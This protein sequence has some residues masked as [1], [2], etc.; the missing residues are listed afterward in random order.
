MHFQNL[1]VLQKAKTYYTTCVEANNNPLLI[2]QNGTALKAIYQD[3]TSNTPLKFAF[4]SANT[5]T[6]HTRL[7]AQEL[8]NISSYLKYEYN[9][10]VL[11]NID[12][13]SNWEN[14]RG[15]FGHKGY[16]IFV[17][18]PTI[19]YTVLQIDEEADIDEDVEEVIE[20]DRK[21]ALSVLNY[22][23]NNKTS[24]FNVFT[25]R[26]ATHKLGLLEFN[27][28]FINLSSNLSSETKEFIQQESFE[29]IVQEPKVLRSLA[30]L[31]K[32]NEISPRTVHNYI[33]YK[34]LDNMA[35]FF[36][37]FENFKTGE[38][39]EL[40]CAKEVSENL[41]DLTSRVYL[42]KVL[43]FSDDRQKMKKH[44][45]KIVERV[46][47]GLQIQIDKLSWMP[48]HTKQLIYK[49]LQYMVRNVMYSNEIIDNQKLTQT[50]S[51]LEINVVNYGNLG[52]LVAE[53][54]LQSVNENGWQW[55]EYAELGYWIDEN[56]KRKFENVKECLRG[57]KVD[58]ELMK[59]LLDDHGAIK[60]AFNAYQLDVD[61][62]GQDNQLPDSI[63]SQLVREQ[64]FFLAYVNGQQEKKTEQINN[65]LMN[66][67]EFKKSFNCRRNDSL[68]PEE[69]CVIW[70]SEIAAVQGIP[71]TPRPSYYV[72]INK[73]PV[74]NTSEYNY[75]SNY[76]MNRINL[77]YQPC[78]NFYEFACS[79]VKKDEILDHKKKVELKMNHKII[80][81]LNT[82]TE[83]E[84][85]YE[86]L[87]KTFYK[88]CI[89]Q[90]YDKTLIYTI[91]N[92]LTT[93]YN[94]TFP[95]LNNGT[96]NKI[97]KLPEIG[98]LA[99][100]LLIN[101]DI[102]PFFKIDVQ[103]NLKKLFNA[104]PYLLTYDTF[105][106]T[107]KPEIY[108]KPEWKAIKQEYIDL[109]AQYLHRISST[110][111]ATMK[112]RTLKAVELEERLAKLLKPLKRYL[113]ADDYNV[114]SFHDFHNILPLYKMSSY[115]RGIYTDNKNY[116]PNFL[117]YILDRHT[118]VA[119]YKKQIQ[120]DIHYGVYTAFVEDTNIF[121]DNILLR[122]ML[123]YMILLPGDAV[124]MSDDLAS[125]FS[126]DYVGNGL[127]SGEK[128]HSTIT[129]PSYDYNTNSFYLPLPYL[130]Y[131]FANSSYP[132]VW[133]FVNIGVDVGRLL[134]RLFEESG[135]ERDSTGRFDQWLSE[136]S[137][138][139]VREMINELEEQYE[140]IS[141]GKEQD[142]NDDLADNVAL[143]IAYQALGSYTL[144]YNDDYSLPSREISLLSSKQLYFL[145]FSQ[146]YCGKETNSLFRV[147]NK[148]KVL[149][150]LSNNIE[151]R[152]VF[153]C[154]K[155]QVYAPEEFVEI[156][157]QKI[158]G[159]VGVPLLE[160]LPP[161]LNI[162]QAKPNLSLK[163]QECA[164][165]FED[166]ID[167]TVDPCEDFYN[168]TCN[169]YSGKDTFTDLDIDNSF[170]LL[171]TLKKPMK[172]DENLAVKA[173]KTYFNKC[174]EETGKKLDNV[175][176]LKSVVKEIEDV[177]GHQFRLQCDNA[178]NSTNPNIQNSNSSQPSPVTSTQLSY[179]MGYVSGKYSESVLVSSM[180]YTNS[181]N[182]SKPY[183]V[184][185][186]AD[187]F[188]LDYDEPENMA[189]GI[190]IVLNE[191]L[192]YVRNNTEDI[193]DQIIED[194]FAFVNLEA[195]LI[196]ASEPSKDLDRQNFSDVYTVMSIRKFEEEYGK[197]F[198]IKAYL[199][200]LIALVPEVENTVLQDDYEVTIED[201]EAFKR[202]VEEL[203]KVLKKYDKYLVDFIFYRTLIMA[204]QEFVPGSTAFD[205]I[206]FDQKIDKSIRNFNNSSNFNNKKVLKNKNNNKNTPTNQ[207]NK[208]IWKRRLPKFP[209]EGI[210]YPKK[211]LDLLS[212]PKASE[213]DV[214]FL[215]VRCL[216][217]TREVFTESLN[218]IFVEAVYPNETTREKERLNAAKVV[219]SI[220]LG[221]R[222]MLRQLSWMDESSKKIAHS[223]ID[224]LINNIAYPNISTNVSALND[225]YKPLH[226]LQEDDYLT[227]TLKLIVFNQLKVVSDLKK[228][229][230]DR[231][232]FGSALDVNAWYQ[233][234]SNS[235]NIPLAILQAPFYDNEWPAAVNYGSIGTVAGHELT[236]S[237]DNHGIQWDGE[238]RLHNWMSP[239]SYHSL[240]NM[241]DC[242][243]E[244]YDNFCYDE[245]HCVNGN[246]TQGENIADNGAIQAAFRAYR[247]EI[248]VTGDTM[249][250]PGDLVGQFTHDQLFFLAFGRMWCT[251]PYSEFYRD[252]VLNEVHSP[253]EFRVL[254]VL[255]NFPEF[256]DAFK[257]WGKKKYAPL[258]HCQVWVTDVEPGL[259]L[260]PTTT[261]LPPLN[262]PSRPT[263]SNNDEYNEA[264]NNILSTLDIAQDPCNNFYDYVCN[265][266]QSATLKSKE[267][268]MVNIGTHLVDNLENDKIVFPHKKLVNTYYNSCVD[269]KNDLVKKKTA[270]VK[271]VKDFENYIGAKWPA[272]DKMPFSIE[273]KADN[274]NIYNTIEGQDTKEEATIKKH[275]NFTE[276][277]SDFIE[278]ASSYLN[279]NYNIKT[280]FN[281]V[282]E[283]NLETS[284]YAYPVYLLHID[285]PQLVLPIEM[286]KNIK[287]YDIIIGKYVQLLSS[288][289][290]ITGA[291]TKH[292][293]K[294]AEDAYDIENLLSECYT[295]STLRQS[296]KYHQN[297]IT[298]KEVQEELKGIKWYTLLDELLK[299]SDS[300]VRRMFLNEKEKKLV[301]KQV[302]STVGVKHIQNLYRK[303]YGNQLTD[304]SLL[305]YFYFRIVWGQKSLL[306]DENA[307]NLSNPPSFIDAQK[308]YCALQ[309]STLP[310]LGSRLFYENSNIILD[311]VKDKILQMTGNIVVSL[312]SLVS[313]AN[314]LSSTVKFRIIDKLQH[315][316]VKVLGD[317]NVMNDEFLEKYYQGV[318]YNDDMSSVDVFKVV[319]VTEIAYDY[320][321]NSLNIP[322]GA[323]LTPFYDPKY[324]MAINF[325]TIGINI[326]HHLVQTFDLYGVQIDKLG[327]YIELDQSTVFGYGNLSIC[328]NKQFGKYV[329]SELSGV[330]AHNAAIHIAKKASELTE[331]YYGHDPAFN[332]DILRQYTDDQ[333]FFIQYTNQFCEHPHSNSD[334]L[335]EPN[336]SAKERILNVLQNDAEFGS[337]FNCPA[338]SKY[339]CRREEKCEL[340]GDSSTTLQKALLLSP[341]TITE[342]DN[343]YSN[344][345]ELSA[346]LDSSLD[347]TADPCN[348]FHQY[349][350]GNIK[351]GKDS[352][353]ENLKTQVQAILNI[354]VDHEPST[355][356]TKLRQYYDQCIDTFT[357]KNYK[358]GQ[359]LKLKLQNF[360]TA[361][362]GKFNPSMYSK[363]SVYSMSL[364]KI[365]SYLQ[366]NED[367]DTFITTTFEGDS[368]EGEKSENLY[369]TIDEPTLLW[370]KERYLDH[371]FD[372]EQYK[373]EVFEVL[374]KFGK[375][376][377]NVKV[378]EARLKSYIDRF[379][380]YEQYMVKPAYYTNDTI[381][382][383]SIPI[384]YPLTR[385]NKWRFLTWTTY[386]TEYFKLVGVQQNG[387]VRYQV[388][389][390]NTLS[391][392]N[393]NLKNFMDVDT[394]ANY[395]FMR[396]IMK[397]KYM[398][399]GVE[400]NGGLNYIHRSN[401]SG[402]T[403]PVLRGL[404]GTLSEPKDTLAEP[405][406]DLVLA[407]KCVQ[408][409][410][411]LFNYANSKA[412]VNYLQQQSNLEVPSFK[413]VHL[414]STIPLKSE[415]ISRIL[416]S[417]DSKSEVTNITNI[418]RMV[419]NIKNEFKATLHEVTSLSQQDQQFLQDKI[420]GLNVQLLYNE[421]I[422]NVEKLDEYYENVKIFKNYFE[423]TRNLIVNMKAKNVS[424]VSKSGFKEVFGIS[425]SE[426]WPRYEPQTNTLIVPYGLIQSTRYRNNDPTYAQYSTLGVEI[427]KGIALILDKESLQ[428]LGNST[429]KINAVTPEFKNKLSVV[430]QC[431]S[432]QIDSSDHDEEALRENLAFQIAYRAFNV[433]L[434]LNGQDLRLPNEV[435]SKL[436]EQQLVFLFYSNYKTRL[437]FENA[438]RTVTNSIVNFSGFRSVFNC[439]KMSLMTPVDLCNVWFS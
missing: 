206:Q 278:K 220:L 334:V 261:T 29:F 50:Y 264:Q 256:K 341:R 176:V 149:G 296:P 160:K 165:Y 76:I 44:V 150:S 181:L 318:D 388:K 243:V 27:D 90:K 222:S 198:D 405:Q 338:G 100:F 26:N 24:Q 418:F 273:T 41:S 362:G 15:N 148:L 142:I 32:S 93:K 124:E 402:G 248:S 151:F 56:S 92:K 75:V 349:S 147:S 336:I 343:N 132:S 219:D 33:V 201:E 87:G 187:G 382:E 247:N 186:S 89:A 258:D 83:N 257:C 123:K 195:D 293:H 200:G 294:V 413:F 353:D 73:N 395:F 393:Q 164:K 98:D 390:K 140:V 373:N 360:M 113:S 194:A 221:F 11:I 229:S 170:T 174:K 158:V 262:I 414:K 155:D 77:E 240:R 284:G 380:M 263:Q 48:Y 233:Q 207:K 250:L 8:A 157:Q 62:N 82:K 323:V 7:S 351:S 12:V 185:L 397:Y 18:Q 416:T 225:Y 383:Y 300:D 1:Q 280:L 310:K 3:I 275:I 328:Y 36:P 289:S 270:M 94:L 411:K 423:T 74:K 183:S 135:L 246:R 13:K 120:I 37:D 141:S 16:R 372:E 345:K 287:Y 154:K 213:E 321:T 279:T 131:D 422:N 241:A 369:F 326:A 162:P 295:D 204:N 378:D 5:T 282:V 306:L 52:V 404:N 398:V 281:I 180:I 182:P 327:H 105:D 408:D 401:G 189:Q 335:A 400:E 96:E 242:V 171:K 232:D 133:N 299:N 305:N 429:R 290:N 352:E 350:S 209:S 108:E 314:W 30:N 169:H 376:W 332:N 431:L 322:A 420:A 285:L 211:N 156:W 269:E 101:F 271:M 19:K 298:L 102:H 245:D 251:E 266:L 371:N 81:Y 311:A 313:E 49:K 430:E 177:F 272:F 115:I 234:A 139:K 370:P 88:T 308:Q 59:E 424:Y 223:K 106:T 421:V 301:D 203:E 253:N 354:V 425:S 208:P 297:L 377:S 337:S 309:S 57:Q 399:P 46:I 316:E 410:Q 210:R 35:Q 70:D 333:L 103:P 356:L 34:L 159:Q 4:L 134:G 116:I 374:L 302:I 65:V 205:I 357:S 79:N 432:L 42:D 363:S 419:N 144:Y 365:L 291:T 214:T 379:L 392:F 259:S 396:L 91:I 2:H 320:S 426:I 381:R 40:K 172:D 409:T 368:R 97:E 153:H 60:S 202:F 391:L 111:L 55:N 84:L 329:S 218:H 67:P 166:S 386:T 276:I 192:Q 331:N 28:Y 355:A 389:F 428:W 227:M 304:E 128:H 122:L 78:D 375:V 437:S 9:V 415:A 110:P 427:A 45:E 406:G 325:G 112:Q 178:E 277:P 385:M 80:E 69:H 228:P 199:S 231:L 197:T 236:H 95:L 239:S 384:M 364:P 433:Y 127:L 361:I 215:D 179:I 145:L 319:N 117:Q 167:N 260:P 315:L 434:E 71:T 136:R 317:M 238:G 344:Y 66:Y 274:E 286:Y 358:D 20:L 63:L 53:S 436:N 254:G 359:I 23:R 417:L 235:I 21:I 146:N 403:G 72:N 58:E 330:I 47:D 196:Q 143:K 173:V 267:K 184:Y 439:P 249:V 224:L 226:L 175:K 119:V 342:A 51:T 138:K 68:A 366:V 407:S 412:Y 191:Y 31:L 435:L 168:Y 114:V 6:D 230:F 99:Y 340:F 283:T 394:Q 288:Y 193:Q 14:P 216:K 10:D 303:I 348:D 22:N 188:F 86:T 39:V 339:T 307:Q 17:D 118:Q 265:H 121:L 107:F 64:L 292:V 387:A 125:A 25:K 126:N 161:P 163:Y 217:P 130:Q 54:L 61:I 104:A 129:V 152:S 438:E 367:L 346:S 237:F 347:L 255:Q 268:T 38:N 43:P 190:A 137:K 109:M 324:P 312:Q 252:L 244:Q 212:H 85:K